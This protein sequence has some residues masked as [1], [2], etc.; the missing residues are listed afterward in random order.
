MHFD[1]LHDSPSDF[2]RSIFRFLDLR[3][4]S[5]I[6]YDRKIFE[7][8][9]ARVSTLAALARKSAQLVRG[10]G[11]PDI[12]GRVKTNTVVQRILYKPFTK[13]SRPAMT[14]RELDYLREWHAPGVEELIELT[15]RNYSAWL[16]IGNP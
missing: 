16:E 1:D 12:V 13:T 4:D 15:G 3:F 6:N 9:A 5:Q 2:I 14:K 7:A 8:A 10:L 11:R